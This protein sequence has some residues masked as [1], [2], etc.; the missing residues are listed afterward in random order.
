MKK[1]KNKFDSFDVLK[2]TLASPDQVL[3]WSYGEVTKAETINYRTFR[4]EPEGLFCE[5]IFG[6]TKN[7][8]CYCGKYKKIRYKG[9]VCDKCGVEVTTSDVRRERMGHIDL[10]IPVAHVWFAFGI[11]NKMSIILDISHKKILSVVYYTRYVII[12]ADE[13]KRSEM[14]DKALAL[15]SDEIEKLHKD[16]EE[17]LNATTE[18]FGVEIEELKKA[19]GKGIELKISQGEHKRKQALAKVRRDYAEKEEQIESFYSKLY[20]TIEKI[21]VGAVITED[22]YSDLVERDL[23]FFEAMMGAEA[24]E[25]LLQNLDL[26]GELEKLRIRIEKEKGEK[27]LATIRRI[28]YLEGFIKNG[29][30]PEWMVIRTLPVLPP[31]LRPIIPLSG[32]KFAT[33]DLNDLYRRIINRNNRLK[34]LIEIGAPDVILRNEKRMLQESVDALIDNSHRPS[35]PMMNSK[36]LPYQS[37]TDDLRGKK[38]IFRKNLLGKRVDYSGRAVIDGDPSLKF[39]QCGIPKSVALEM[40]KPFVIY[41]LLDKELAPNVR[42]AKDMLEEETDIIW[43]LLEEVIKNK[44]VLLNR[45]PTLHKYSVQAFYPRLVEGEAIRIHPL[46]CKAFNADFDGD[47]MAVHILL[48]DEAIEEAKKEMMSSQNIVNI[49][50]GQ[51]LASPAKD[52]LIGFYMMTDLVESKNP[53]IFATSDLAIKAYERDDISINEEILVG[54]KG[55]AI[56][57]SVGRV[58]FNSILPEDY[59]FINERIDNRGIK[60]IIDKIKS[61]SDLSVVVELLDNMKALG[62]KFATDLAFSFAMEDCQVDFDIKSEIKKIEEKDEQLLD[63][64]L[65]GLITKKEKVNISTNMWDDFADELAEMAWDKLPK[66]NSIYQMVESGGNGGK[67]QARQVLTIKGVVRDSRGNLVAMPIK[68]NYRD[69]LSAFEYFVA[70]NGGRKGI[71]DRSLKTSSSGYLTRKLVDVAHDVIIRHDDCGYDGEGLSIRKSDDRRIDFKDRI[72]GRVLAKDLVIGKNTIAKR[73]EIITQE[74]AEKVEEAGIDEVFVRT[75]LLCKSPL[76]MCK[77]CYGYNLENNREIDMGRAVGVIAAQSIGEPGTQM[78]MQTFH[79]GGVQK[80]DITQGLP[81]IEELFEART[82][83]AEAEMASIDGKIHIEVAEDDSSTIILSGEKKMERHYI[84][85]KAKKLLVEDEQEVKA[86]QAMFIDSD[87]VERQAPFDGTISLEGGILTING[88]MKAEET[89]YVLPGIEILVEDGAEVKAGTQL[90]EGSLDPKKLADVADILTS[91]KYILDEVQ[92]VFNA[93]GVPIDDIHIEIIL[94]QMVR[95]GRVLD[96]GDSEYLVGSSVNRFMA[97]LKNELL[98]KDGK[99]K[100]LVIPKLYGIKTSSLNTES[101]LSAIS[102]QEQVRVLTNAAIIGKTDYLRGMKENVIIGKPIPVGEGAE[103]KNMNELEE[104]QV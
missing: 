2:V 95:L 59:P 5:K 7:Y 29:I 98:V 36:R 37:L 11:P 86:G 12:S 15:K 8:E 69:G 35:K 6:P 67:I 16:L 92:K 47:Q 70:A 64:Y 43:D 79:K 103:I 48:T 62:F 77:K 68:S 99:N 27:K 76:G 41:K 20:Q 45:A 21:A 96:S 93:Q 101:F 28:Q 72:F 94:R 34:K 50:N 81:R 44:P 78:T 65:Q 80:I 19:K 33:S 74:I 31:E 87:Q 54:I 26:E 88:R 104:L 38:G 10:A 83:K 90:T 58:I 57:T 13:E 32:G 3:N 52:M 97:A 30:K 85:S 40:F 82:P 46:V 102:F 71:A 63:N 9:I 60:K 24:I 22:E 61:S 14:M 84:V 100:A 42:V 53:R 17:D 18:T 55:E 1:N 89:I 75:P 91:Q 23:V 51:V 66:D 39:D 4:A 49:S 56:K 25:K 73:N